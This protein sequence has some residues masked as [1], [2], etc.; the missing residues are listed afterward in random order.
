MNK[1]DWVTF[2]N[3][4]KAIFPGYHIT[5]NFAPYGGEITANGCVDC[6][7]VNGKNYSIIWRIYRNQSLKSA[8]LALESKIQTNKYLKS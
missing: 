8:I 6:G 1:M 5:I 2:E 4:I 3:K 7:T